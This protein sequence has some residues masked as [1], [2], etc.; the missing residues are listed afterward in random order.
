MNDNLLL[1]LTEKEKMLLS[2]VVRLFVEAGEP[3]S[4]SVNRNIRRVSH[5]FTLVELVELPGLLKK[6]EALR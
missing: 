6:I 5:K 4:Y 2:T 1:L 3:D